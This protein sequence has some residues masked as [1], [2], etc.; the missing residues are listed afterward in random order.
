MDRV[1]EKLLGKELSTMGMKH[2]ICI[3]IAKLGVTLYSVIRSGTMQ[4]LL[5]LILTGGCIAH[6]VLFWKRSL[7]T[8]A[9]WQQKKVL[10]LMYY[11]NIS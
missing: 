7:K 2:K 8:G 6:Q 10:Q 1:V 3:N 5:R 4:I 9:V 11:V